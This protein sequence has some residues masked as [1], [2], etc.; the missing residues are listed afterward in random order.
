MRVNTYDRQALHEVWAQ[1]EYEDEHFTIGPNDVVVD[2]GAHIG[3]FSVWAAKQATSGRVYAFEPNQENYRLLEENKQ[4][5]NLTNLH[6]FNLAV[7]NQVGEAVLF[8]SDHH[9]LSHSFF[10]VGAPNQTTVRTTSLAEILQ[11]NGIHR[12]NYL[13]IDAEGAEYLIVLN[14]PA[15]ALRRI[16]KIIIEYHDYLN[17]DHTYQDLEKYLAENGFEVELGASAVQR[18]LLKIGLLK[19][20]RT[21]FQEA[22]LPSEA[23]EYEHASDLSLS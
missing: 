13:K 10:E 3:T 16:D 7:S 11:A 21:D 19:A 20:R 1:K 5:N 14:T 23:Y 17:H 18:A 22:S 12:V 2:I 6:L 15:R 4:L 8:N 9:S